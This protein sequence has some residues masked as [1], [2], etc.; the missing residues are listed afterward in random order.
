MNTVE[1]IMF[2]LQSKNL[3]QKDLADFLGVRRQTITDWKSG[4]TQSYNKYIEKIA[5][6]FNVSVDYLLD[7][8]D[9]ANGYSISNVDTTIN[10]NQAHI[11]N[12]N[13]SDSND[14]YDI[15]N[16]LNKLSKTDKLRAIA[17]IL[18]LLE[19]KYKKKVL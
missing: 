5:N 9:E 18:D 16:F 19:E 12:N 10:R 15:Q 6:Y 14:L 3:E 1:K 7:R 8:T 2:L 13:I 11:I 4:K 17:D